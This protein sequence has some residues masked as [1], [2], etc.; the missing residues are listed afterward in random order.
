MDDERSKQQGFTLVELIVVILLI[1]IVSVFAASR[2]LGISSFSAFTAQDQVIS[3]I[4]QVQVNRIQTNIPQLYD[5]CLDATNPELQ[6]ICLR[7]RITISADCVGSSSGCNASDVTS[8]SDVVIADQVTF[9]SS[10]S[11]ILF[12]LLGNP[13]GAAS[14]G[15]SISITAGQSSTNV[16]INPQGYVYGG[17]C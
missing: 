12:D 14:N 11:P 5:Y 1:A 2:Y 6:Q 13:I 8:R 10:V 17:S 16:C 7:S 4:R 15:V 9:N 3:V